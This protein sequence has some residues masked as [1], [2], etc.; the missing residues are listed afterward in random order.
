MDEAD[1]N[2]LGFIKAADKPPTTSTIAKGLFN[3]KDAYEL[4]LKDNFIRKRLKKLSMFL[5]VTKKGEKKT[6]FCTKQVRVGVGELSLL[7][8]KKRKKTEIGLGK[9][10]VLLNGKS[11]VIQSI[12]I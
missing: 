7:E 4:R 3:P 2:I 1:V 12:E 6:Y 8:P 11:V 9:L 10:I 5:K